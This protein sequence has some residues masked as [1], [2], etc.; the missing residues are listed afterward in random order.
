MVATEALSASL[1]DYL[2][3]IFHIVHEKQAARGKDIAQR[4]KVNR[5]SVTGALHALADRSLINYAPY[6]II[7]LTDEG[8]LIAK[9]IVRKHEALRDFFVKVLVVDKDEAEQ[10]KTQL[11]E[12]GATAVIE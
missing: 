7:T 2:E 12:A 1:E 9:E 3:A 10:A 6:D 5:S 8:D 11:E 4:L